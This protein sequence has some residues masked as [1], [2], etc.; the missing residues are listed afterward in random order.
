MKIY[1]ITQ[2]LFGCVVFPGDTAPERRVMQSIEA[3]DRC[4]LSDVLMCAHNGTHIDAPYHFVEGGDTVEKIPLFKTVGECC[5]LPFEGELSGEDAKVLLEVA[6]AF[7][8]QCAKRILL[9]GEVSVSPEGAQV[10]L[11]AGLYLLGVE[12]QSVAAESI[13]VV[14]R[15]LLGSGVVLLEGVRLSAVPDGAYFLSAAPI[16]MSGSDGAPCRAIL[17]D[18][19]NTK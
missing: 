11:A 13:A 8:G 10:L 4:N 5:V 7:G 17:I 1:D 19:I 3:G 2:E 9:R 16:C 12:P 15:C 14:H 6:S 18:S